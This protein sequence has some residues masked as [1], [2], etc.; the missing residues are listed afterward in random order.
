MERFEVVGEV[1]ESDWRRF[2]GG[3]V[4]ANVFHTPE[5]FEVFSRARGHR[6]SIWAAAD[7]KGDIA[8]MMVPVEVT[9]LDQPIVRKFTTRA[10]MY[11]GVAASEGERGIEALAQLLRAYVDGIGRN[12]LFTE[13]RHTNDPSRIRPALGDWGARHEDHL[14]FLIDLRR[15]AEDIWQGIAASARRNIRKAERQGVTF[16]DVTSPDELAE[17]Y[18]LLCDVY[19]HISVPLPHVSLFQAALDILVPRGMLR[20]L[21]AQAEGRMIGV[22]NLLV[23][24]GVATYW[25]TGAPRQFSRFRPAD[26]LVWRGIE[27]ARAAGAHTFDFGGGGRPDEEYGVREFKA[28]FGGTLVDFGRDTAIHAPVRY[29]LSTWGFELLRRYL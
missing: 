3:T 20:I 6:P 16:V 17:A 9:V 10:V 14:N 27:A 11:G 12:V 8:A 28:K 19:E 26:S 1:D 15:P 7:D 29:R 24:N 25:Y 2:V 21:A 4:G 13:I 23:F 18:Q 22:L 5:M